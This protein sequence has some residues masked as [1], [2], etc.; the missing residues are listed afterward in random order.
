M[1]LRTAMDPA[2]GAAAIQRQV[3]AMDRDL[4]IVNIETQADFAAESLGTERLMS[5]LAGAFAILALA[6]ASI[7]LYG[8]LAYDVAQRSREIA[9]RIAIGAKPSDLLGLV[10]RHGLRLVVPGGIVGLAGALAVP[11]VLTSILFGVGPADPLTLAGTALLLGLVALVACY[12]PA[13]RAMAGDPLLALRS[14]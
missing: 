10:F 5:K 12:L 6:L 13:R 14:S 1:E 4:P 9:I 11:S 7:G 3:R 2:A 8:V